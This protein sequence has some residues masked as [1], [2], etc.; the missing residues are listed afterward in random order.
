M[1]CK[2]CGREPQADG[3]PTHWLGCKA[4]KAERAPEPPPRAAEVPEVAEADNLADLPVPV[5]RCTFG[6]CAN[7][8]RPQGKGPK[9]KYCDD[10]R[11]AKS[12][13]EK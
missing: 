2:H 6:E 4:K 10:H 3:T 7:P 11:T 13:K 9:P 12:R 5:D 1:S 8:K